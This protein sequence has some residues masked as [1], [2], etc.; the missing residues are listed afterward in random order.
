MFLADS[1]VLV[2]GV[3]LQSPYQ[4]MSVVIILQVPFIKPQVLGISMFEPWKPKTKGFASDCL[5]LSWPN[6]INGN[7]LYYHSAFELILGFYM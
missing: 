2:G 7:A 5:G 1:Y 3:F 4:K 6:S